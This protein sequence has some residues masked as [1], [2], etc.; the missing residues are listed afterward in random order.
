MANQLN[1]RLTNMET[2]RIGI[3]EDSEILMNVLS[4]FMIIVI[5]IGGAFVIIPIVK[6]AFIHSH[7]NSV[8][9]LNYDESKI[10]SLDDNRI[11]YLINI[12]S[13]ERKPFITSLIKRFNSKSIKVGRNVYTKECKKYQFTTKK[14]IHKKIIVGI[15]KPLSEI[16]DETM[17]IQFDEAIHYSLEQLQQ[18]AKNPNMVNLTEEV[19]R[20]VSLVKEIKSFTDYIETAA[21]IET[22]MFKVNSMYELLNKHHVVMDQLTLLVKLFNTKNYHQLEKSNN[23]LAKGRTKKEQS[24][25]NKDNMYLFTNSYEQIDNQ[26]DYYSSD[27]HSPSYNSE[28]S[29]SSDSSSVNSD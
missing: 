9:N 23:S 18:F 14:Q 11:S 20:V 22:E 5:G 29:V 28:V 21:M 19:D 24:A 3:M 16:K 10:F 4:L 15:V 12:K 8:L 25:M 7:N 17:L 1:G 2:E 27:N 13:F 6:N 26:N